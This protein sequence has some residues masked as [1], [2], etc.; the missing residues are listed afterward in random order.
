MCIILANLLGKCFFLQVMD[1]W[2]MDVWQSESLMMPRKGLHVKI[3]GWVRP[4]RTER[5]SVVEVGNYSIWG[6]S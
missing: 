2:I 1:S 3:M 5:E 4:V 6:V